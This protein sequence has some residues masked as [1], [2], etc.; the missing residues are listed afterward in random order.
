MK[1]IY[2]NH[3]MPFNDKKVE[4]VMKITLKL[5]QSNNDLE[6]IQDKEWTISVINDSSVR[7]AFFIPGGKLF[8]FIKILDICDNDEQ[9]AAII[10]HEMAHELLSHGSERVY[11]Q[12]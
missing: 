6:Q 2:K 12:N 11:Y 5:I 1:E 4:K 7:N 10:A 9:L 8:L 3:F